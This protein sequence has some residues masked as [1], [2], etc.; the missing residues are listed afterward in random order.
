MGDVQIPTRVNIVA[1]SP[2]LKK[3]F[4]K[5]KSTHSLR[6][7]SHS[8]EIK[9]KTDKSKLGVVY[10]EAPFIALP[11]YELLKLIERGKC[12]GYC[13]EVLKLYD[14]GKMKD[15]G[16]K[17]N[18]EKQTTADK[19]ERF[20]N[21]LDCSEC[22]ARFCDKQ[23]KLLD[24]KHELLHHR[25]T[26]KTATHPFVDVDGTDKD[27]F[28]F[29]SWKRLEAIIL[30]ENNDW[31]Y[32][33]MMCILH[34]YHDP[35]LETAFM[36][37]RCWESNTSNDTIRFLQEKS[38]EWKVSLEVIHSLL[39]EC[40]KNFELSYID[41]LKYISIYCL[42]NYQ[43]SIYLIFSALNKSKTI[44][45]NLRVEPFDGDITQD[46]EEFVFKK[47][48]DKG[49]RLLKTHIV[50]ES[51]VKPIYTNRTSGILD[52]K[53]IQIMCTDM[54]SSGDTLV[55]L[56]Q[57]YSNPLEIEDD[58]I[59]FISDDNDAVDTPRIIV[60]ITPCTGQGIVLKT[61]NPRLRKASFTSSG[62]S[63]GEGIIKY[64]RDQIR[65]MLENI[66]NNLIDEESADDA[67]DVIADDVSSSLDS[68][69]NNEQSIAKVMKNLQI[70]PPHHQR[71][72]S[73]KFED[74][75]TTI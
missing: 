68:M 11:N 60:P 58:E 37:L 61:P 6:Y 9:L 55:L 31:L 35:S 17:A 29:D 26:N 34:I 4:S 40:F 13:G 50:D 64:N 27:T 73:V 45:P 52:K 22:E 47:T 69:P 10:M 48:D 66:S 36:S 3:I 56:D 53:I 70:N 57:D 44:D 24:F 67:D 51:T 2:Y 43:G 25:P 15:D 65:E 74:H 46:Y 75:V 59:A 18:R 42:N 20:I 30:A 54:V 8:D 71:R 32:N 14:V 72:K 5:S 23:C 63:F 28:F 12:C 1:L 19:H 41:F 38:L 62:N 49:V 7:D 21:G 39:L 33:S 16:N